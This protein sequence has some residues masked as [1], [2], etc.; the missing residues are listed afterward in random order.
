MMMMM[1]MMMMTTGNPRLRLLV[2]MADNQQ[3]L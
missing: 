1:M 2:H 3:Q